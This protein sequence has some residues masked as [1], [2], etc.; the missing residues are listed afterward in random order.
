MIAKKLIIKRV[1]ILL[2]SYMALALNIVNAKTFIKGEIIAGGIIIVNVSPGST[3]KLNDESI[4]ISDKGVFLVGFE[5]KPQPTQILEIYNENVLVEKITLNVKIRSYEIQRINGIKKEK[6]DPP[7]SVI[8]RIYMERNSVKESRKKSNLITST[9]YNNGFV[10]PAKGPISGVYGS[11]RILNGKPR[12]PH[13]GI[14]IALPKG[15]EVVSPM[16]GIVVFSNNDLYYSGGTIIIAHGQG[17]TTSYL[18]LSEILVSVNDIVRRGELIGKV[19]ATGRATGPHLHWGAELK[20][21]RIDPKY[22]DVFN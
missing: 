4:M 22:L 1:I 13:Y 2:F 7:Q 18:H 17:L 15:H 3:V 19:G 8:D 11:Q 5:R 6:V 16:D 20:G 14:D 9:Y 12:S 21:K 10:L